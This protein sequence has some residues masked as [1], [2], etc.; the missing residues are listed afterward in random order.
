MVVVPPSGWGLDHWGTQPLDLH[1]LHKDC[2]HHLQFELL[3][4]TCNV[5]TSLFDKSGSLSFI[6]SSDTS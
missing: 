6:V 1:Q 5:N 4:L 3:L 2:A